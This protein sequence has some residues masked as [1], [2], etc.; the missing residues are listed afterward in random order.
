MSLCYFG[1]K[2]LES[3]FSR[4]GGGRKNAIEAKI[5]GLGRVMVSPRAG[6]DE[7]DGGAGEGAAV[8]ERDGVGEMGVVNFGERGGAE[9]ERLFDGHDEFVFRI[10]FGELGAFGRGDA[11]NFGTEKIVGVGDVN[12]QMSEAHL[13][14]RGLERKFVGG[15][16]FEGGRHVFA[17]TGEAEAQGVADGTSRG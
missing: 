7:H 15:H 10:G 5:H 16:G 1:L 2:Q 3:V 6:E 17:G 4:F 9:F 12:G 8:E 11:R 14:W 13:V